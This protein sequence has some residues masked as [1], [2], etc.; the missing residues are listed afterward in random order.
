[1]QNTNIFSK[2]KKLVGK[3]IVTR[4]GKRY[5]VQKNSSKQVYA[6]NLDGNGYFYMTGKYDEDGVYDGNSKRDI[7]TVYDIKEGHSLNGLD[8]EIVPENIIFS[9][10]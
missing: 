3:V 6:M 10:D 1:M 7:M 2:L 5:I 4:S 8:E 9:R